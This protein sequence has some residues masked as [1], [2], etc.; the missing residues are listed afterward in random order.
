MM[1]GQNIFLQDAQEFTFNITDKGRTL[2]TIRRAVKKWAG[3]TFNALL[4]IIRE[5]SIVNYSKYPDGMSHVIKG[6]DGEFLSDH[7]GRQPNGWARG[8]PKKEKHLK[9]ESTYDFQ[10]DEKEGE[11]EPPEIP[12]S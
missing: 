2:S 3:E 10:E 12:F 7:P 4:R 6:D 5:K 1:I 11:T 8:R 9:E